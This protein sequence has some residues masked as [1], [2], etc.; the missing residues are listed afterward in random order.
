MYIGSI[1]H[2]AVKGDLVEWDHLGVVQLLDPEHAF[3]AD[4]VLH[5]V[6]NHGV[7][8]HLVAI[9]VVLAL[10]DDDASIQG[11][12]GQGEGAVTDYVA[13]PCPGGVA[14]RHLAKLQERLWVHGEGA[15][16]IHEL[17]E[18]RRRG[19]E[20]YLE[21]GLIQGF[22]ADLTEIGNLSLEVSLGVHH[23]EEHVG[24]LVTGH[25]VECA[26]P[27]PDVIA[28]RHLLTV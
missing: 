14:V 17:D 13:H 28:S 19:V 24:V 10:L 12:L 7:Q 6:K 8:R 27:A 23:R 20:R 15:V 11:P 3:L 9:P 5:G 1:G 18:I 25:G 16:V 2:V 22:D 21:G 26:V 4:H